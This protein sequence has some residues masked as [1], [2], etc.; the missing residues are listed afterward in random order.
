MW[1][2][3]TTKAQFPRFVWV[4]LALGILIGAGALGYRILTASSVMVNGS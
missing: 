4:V 3:L 1:N 2:W